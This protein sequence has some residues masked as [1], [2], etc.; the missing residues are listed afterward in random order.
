[1]PAGKVIWALAHPVS[2]EYIHQRGGIGYQECQLIIT[3]KEQPVA[4]ELERY[5]KWAQ[6]MII[7]S[8]KNGDLINSGDPIIQE[9]QETSE[10]LEVVEKPKEKPK[11]RQAQQNKDE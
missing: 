6:T 9:K 10:T 1:M 5:P 2:K 3:E 11:K 4:I 8:I 7:S